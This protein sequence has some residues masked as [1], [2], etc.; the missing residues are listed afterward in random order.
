MTKITKRSEIK[1]MKGIRNFLISI[2]I[3]LV[4]IV[5]LFFYLSLPMHTTSVVYVPKGNINKTI[6]YLNERNFNISPL[7][8]KYLLVFLGKPQA[9]WINMQETDLSKGDFLYRLTNAKAATKSVIIFPGETTEIVFKELAKAFNLSFVDLKARYG[10]Y[11]WLKDG[12]IIPETYNM[13]LGISEEHLIKYLLAISNITYE[14]MSNKIF[15]SYDKKRWKRYLII[16]SIIQ[17]EAGN[18]KEMPLVSSVIYN[19]LK[20]GMKLQMDGALNYG[21]Y[22]HVGVTARR[23][24]RDNTR[25]NTYKH[26]G[27]PPYPICLVSMAALK[28]AIFPKKTKYLYF[29]RDKRSRTNGHIFSKTYMEHLRYIN[30]Q[31]KIR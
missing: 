19:R 8:D 18:E 13:P 25:F 31:K 20:K 3:V 5:S 15:K 29:L 16:A 1:N 27:L 22:S 12:L 17:K 7:V 4:I 28:A 21:K 14:N 6:A 2:D 9:G 24:D 30:Q 26:Y 10:L 11:S 23:I